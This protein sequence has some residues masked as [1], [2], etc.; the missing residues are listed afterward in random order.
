MAIWRRVACWISKA[1]HAQTRRACAP[2][3]KRAGARMHTYTHTHTQKFVI[4]LFPRQQWFRKRASVLRYT[5]I[6]CLVLY[7]I[8]MNHVL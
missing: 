4:L 6:V 1:T 7:I 5:Y 8:Q 3:H 2:T